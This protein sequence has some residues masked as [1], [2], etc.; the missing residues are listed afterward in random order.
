MIGLIDAG[1]GHFAVG[2]RVKAI[3]LRFQLLRQE[4]MVFDDAVVYE[5]DA[6][7]TMRVCVALIRCAVRCPARVCDA[8]AAADRTLFQPLLQL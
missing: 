6:A 2:L 3:A 8:A 4:R 5:R 1:A 7:L